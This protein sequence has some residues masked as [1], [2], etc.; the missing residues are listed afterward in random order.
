VAGDTGEFRRRERELRRAVA[1]DGLGLVR[2][3]DADALVPLAVLV[4]AW[5][6]FHAAV[7]SGVPAP[8]HVESALAGWRFLDGE[9]F[10]P[11]GPTLP[12]ANAWRDA[13]ALAAPIGHAEVRLQFATWLSGG[14]AIYT[15]Y[16]LFR[17]WLEPLIGLLAATLV[18]LHPTWIS[19][20]CRG[21]PALLGTLLMLLGLYFFARHLRGREEVF[22]VWVL[23]GG[24]SLAIG[25]LA[26]G[27]A[28]ALVP[29]IG[30]GQI[31]F[32]SRRRTGAPHRRHLAGRMPTLLGGI[33]VFGIALAVTLR[34]I[35][36]GLVVTPAW[37]DVGTVATAKA[38]ARALLEPLLPLTLGWP[39]VVRHAADRLKALFA[40]DEEAPHELFPLVGLLITAGTI[41]L[42][43]PHPAAI[44][45]AA[46]LGGAA[47]A[48]ALAR[49]FAEPVSTPLIPVM[50][51]AGLTLTALVSPWERGGIEYPRDAAV[52]LASAGAIASLAALGLRPMAWRRLALGAAV[53]VAIGLMVERPFRRLAATAN[54]L[55]AN[56]TVVAGSSGWSVAEGLVV[57]DPPEAPLP[58]LAEYLLRVRDTRPERVR[59]LADLER[60]L[61]ASRRRTAV[62][63][64]A[65]LRS[66]PGR[67]SVA[68]GDWSMTL[69]RTVP[70]PIVRLHLPVD[71]AAGGGRT[72]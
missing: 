48:T 34:W 61:G 12:P 15:L 40:G 28:A 25:V 54:E 5:M 45:M 8:A 22:S 20:F 24:F 69:V 41:L 35:A 63:S 32:W 4:I 49:L 42:L 66:L 31:L 14:L 3:P 1:G 68:S 11:G 58:P 55:G 51:A 50:L 39:A 53:M 59:D 43:G 65:E 7:S 16:R 29:L 13:L 19:A 33:L 6:T 72:P 36:A 52:W 30:F 57:V 71:L 46:A 62:L 37:T 21:D 10:L 18:A 67:L 60:V 56:L 27:W 2:P 26:A 17:L 44:L 38:G 47:V 9:T 23:F 70:G 64:S